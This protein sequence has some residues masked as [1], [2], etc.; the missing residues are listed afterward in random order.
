MKNIFDEKI[1]E[2]KKSS[3]Q[4]TAEVV[5][6]T[7]DSLLSFVAPIETVDLPSKGYFYDPRHLYIIKVL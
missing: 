4:T 1:E 3:T 6:S 7:K 5:T 2:F